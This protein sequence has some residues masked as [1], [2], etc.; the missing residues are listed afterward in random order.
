MDSM[1]DSRGAHGAARAVSPQGVTKALIVAATTLVALVALL[2]S[3]PGASADYAFSGSFSGPGF[4]SGL[5]AT[6]GRAA[7]EQSTG[8]LFVADSGN[9]RVQV[10]RP[11]ATGTADYLTEF[12]VG[13]LDGP[14][15]IAIVESAGQTTVYVTSQTDGGEIVK[16]DSD[17]A[18]TPAFTLDGS[19][20]SPAQGTGAG[21]V[22]NFRSA[23]AAASNGDLW[24][25]DSGNDVLKRFTASGAHVAGSNIDG[26]TSGTAFTGLLDV[27]VNSTGD[28]YVIDANGNIAAGLGT[29][30]ALRFSPSGAFKTALSPVGPTQRPATVTVDRGP[31]TVF[32]SGG[33]DAVNFDLSPTLHVFDSNDAP[34]PAPTLNAQW[35]TVSGIAVADAGDRMYVVLDY[36]YWNGTPYGVP[37]IQAFKELWPP[38][39]TMDP[40]AVSAVTPTGATLSGTVDPRGQAT[41]WHFEYRRLVAGSPWVSTPSQSAGDGEGD[42]AVEADIAGL[43]RNRAYEARLRAVNA[44]GESVS[45]RESFSTAPDAPVAETLPA[46][47]AEAASVL[48]RGRVNPNGTP[49]TYRFELGETTAYDREIALGD[50]SAGNGQDPVELA[51]PVYDL[52]PGVTYHYRIVATNVAGEDAGD[53]VS[54]TLGSGADSCPNAE[55]RTGPSAH[56]PDCRAYELLS[57]R[58]NGGVPAPK[59]TALV[60]PDGLTASWLALGQGILPG[61]GAVGG[62]SSDYLSRRGSDGW[63]TRATT[64]FVS[65]NSGGSASLVTWRGEDLAKVVLLQRGLSPMPDEAPSG[66]FRALYLQDSSNL[67]LT[68][69]TRPAI[70]NPTPEQTFSVDGA[71]EDLSRIV[72]TAYPPGGS[73][74]RLVPE[75]AGRVS[76]QGVYLYANGEVSAIGILPDGTV[77]PGGARMPTASFDSKWQELRHQVSDD[78]RRVV[79]YARPTGA[80][81]E[82][83]YMRRDGEDTVPVSKSMLTGLPAAGSFE[84][85]AP[86]GSRV[87][88]RA[89]PQLTADAPT[90]VPGVLRTYEFDLASQTVTYLPEV[91]GIYESSDDGSRFMYVREDTSELW[92]SDRGDRR[93]IGEVNFLNADA[94]HT[95]ATPDG[96][97][98][99]FLSGVPFGGGEF[100][101]GGGRRQAYLYDVENRRLT[102]VSCPPAGV[103]P[104]GD[105]SITTGEGGLSD[106]PLV[107]PRAERAVTEDG[108]VVF[109]DTPD[110]LVPSD[111]NGTED[112]YRWSESGVALISDGRGRHPSFVAD[113]TPTGETVLLIT[114]NS[115]SSED[116]DEERDIYSVRV[117]GGYPVAATRETCHLDCQGPGARPPDDPVAATSGA[118][119]QGNAVVAPRTARSCASLSRAATRAL[120]S[121]ARLRRQAGRAEGRRAKRLRAQARKQQRRATHLKRRARSCRSKASRAERDTHTDR[122]TAR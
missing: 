119:G 83:L 35:N 6:P 77:P 65:V 7:V 4:G 120:R 101:N 105:V 9:D 60:S 116:T 121:A 3:A 47:Q 30:R 2:A 92:I 67:S 16:F 26:A 54:F 45:P 113:T 102:C 27:A 108:S 21:Q 10:F 75:D 57:P 58:D 63:T 80:V 88:F 12:G 37:G 112:V 28:L 20:A 13:L 23:I 91:G 73:A 33:Q 85:A 78:G 41:D 99:L 43:E 100:N 98:F 48:L 76:G 50:G 22:G 31:D 1:V 68:W 84:Y 97:H 107:K 82:S 11:N 52:A 111:V 69:I 114:R 87:W 72:F 74:A 94:R 34:Q 44:D 103:S 64:P 122:R 8:N 5:V 38:K 56:L 71:A 115:L 18:A 110:P 86:D 61:T 62:V 109:F 104:T 90:S 40:G 39:S 59:H 15:G 25:A 53:D 79:F 55:Y 14:W 42:V 106:D 32:V 66:S 19:Y 93:R 24:V 46:H 51:V 118:R 17:E 36:G 96:S 81:Q 70:P 95:R 49:T 29:S 89:S 117:G